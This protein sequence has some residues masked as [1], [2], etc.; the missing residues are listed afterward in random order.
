MLGGLSAVCTSCI[1]GQYGEKL[2]TS[3]A[4]EGCI[5]CPP[6]TFSSAFGASSRSASLA[7]SARA[8]DLNA[9]CNYDYFLSRRRVLA[10][11]RRDRVKY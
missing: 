5:A 10:L 9:V 2:G 11:P 8:Y 6:G 7:Q 3:S 1:P 4:A